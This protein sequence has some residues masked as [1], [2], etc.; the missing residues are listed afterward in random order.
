MPRKTFTGGSVLTSAEVNTFLMDQA[1][2]VFDDSAARTTAIPAPIEGM[3]TY[4]K[5]TDLVQVWTGAEWD[6]VSGGGSITVSDTAPVGPESGDLWFNSVLGRTFVWYVDTDSSQWVEVGAGS[7]PTAA[8][9]STTAPASAEAGQLWFDSETGNL[10]FYY[11]DVDGGQWIQV[12]SA[13]PTVSLVNTD[14]DPGSTI[15]VGS[16]DPDGV[17]T[18]AAGDVWI[19][20]PSGS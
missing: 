12:R 8:A 4:L 7:G 17:Y 19:E 1:V 10:F 5:D 3:I 11:V 18:L 20:V 16:V 9:V 2:M 13:A 6:E 15:Y 14:G